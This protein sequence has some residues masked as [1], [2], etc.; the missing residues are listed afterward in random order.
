M[1]QSFDWTILFKYILELHNKILLFLLKTNSKAMKQFLLLLIC[2]TIVN[3]SKAQ[4]LYQG[5]GTTSFVSE[6]PLEV[7]KGQTDKLAGIVDMSNN[8]FAFKVNVASFNGFNSALQREHFNEHYLETKKF[9]DATFLGTLLVEDDCSTGCETQALCKGK[10]TI[11]G[12]TQIVT[13][14]VELSVA[15]SI[16]K[17]A[18]SFKVKLS[19]YNIK[20]PKIVQ[21]KIASEIDVTVEIVMQSDI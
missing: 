19:D 10:F 8:N 2:L 12:I 6:A 18:G 17:I 14:P 16:I 1:V 11:H 21:A 9:P 15:E 20:I 13:I 4:D 7:I 3:L 5:E